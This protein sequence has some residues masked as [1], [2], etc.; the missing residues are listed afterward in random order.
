MINKR[1]DLELVEAAHALGRF[2]PY[3][4]KRRSS[5]SGEAGWSGDVLKVP[6]WGLKPKQRKTMHCIC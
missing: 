1:V 2:W 3:R 4:G 6:Q 5:S